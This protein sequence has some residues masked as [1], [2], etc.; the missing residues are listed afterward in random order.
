[1]GSVA[2]KLFPSK[3]LIQE[4]RGNGSED[5]KKVVCRFAVVIILMVLVVPCVFLPIF[6]T[7]NPR[8]IW[9]QKLA[10]ILGDQI[11]IF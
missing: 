4:S 5:F 3:K 1:L 6:F 7:T 10:Q 11:S 2:L 9:M 8:P